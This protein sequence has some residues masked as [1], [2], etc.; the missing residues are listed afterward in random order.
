MFQSVAK[1][2]TPIATILLSAYLTG[3]RF[4][5]KND[6]AFSLI[7]LGGVTLVT[8]GFGLSSWEQEDADEEFLEE[9]GMDR[10]GDWAGIYEGKP[11]TEVD[12][13]HDKILVI[14]ACIGAFAL[15]FLSAYGSII[16]R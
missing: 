7:S 6:L 5:C 16:T 2:L 10:D 1:N 14:L 15:P 12:I 13:N 8:L 4:N 9:L 11:H 3:E